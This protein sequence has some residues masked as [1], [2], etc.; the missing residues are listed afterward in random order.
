M[1]MRVNHKTQ[2]DQL[3]N[4]IYKITNDLEKLKKQQD[5]R[6][7]GWEEVRNKIQKMKQC[8]ESN[9]GIERSLGKKERKIWKQY[10]KRLAEIE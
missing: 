3:A 4:K 1:I 5:S 8:G 6:N 9:E 2:I 7:K 10:R